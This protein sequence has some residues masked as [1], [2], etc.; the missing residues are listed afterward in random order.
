MGIGVIFFNVSPVLHNLTT[1]MYSSNQPV[2][3]SYVHSC[4]YALPFDYTTKFVGYVAVF[5][6]NCFLTFDAGS[7]LCVYDLYISVIVFHAWGHLKILDYHLR[8]FPR[9]AMV[10]NG[11]ETMNVAWYSEEESKEVMALLKDYV[12]YHRMIMK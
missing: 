8:N 9:P 2:N 4:Y 11:N 7:C 12:N 1:G 5:I 6:T 3:G 10:G